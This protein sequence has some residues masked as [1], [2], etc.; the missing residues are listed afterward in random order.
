[1]VVTRVHIRFDSISGVKAKSK[2]RFAGVEIGY[3]EEISLENGRAKVTVKLDPNV[4]VPANAKFFIGS[5]G[6]MGDKFIAISGGS[7]KAGSLTTD[8]SV[9]G[10]APVDMDQ[11]MA[12]L[13]RI[14]TGYWR[15]YNCL[16]ERNRDRG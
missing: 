4:K 3:V 10:D 2:V 14:G 8:D 15:N 5:S 6:L 16:E 1:M 7:D 9:Y 11:L 12:S 13:N